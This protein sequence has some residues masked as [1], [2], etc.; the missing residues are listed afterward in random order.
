MAHTTLITDFDNTLYDWFHFWYHS[1]NAMLSV[2][3]RISGIGEETLIPQIRA[4]HQK[5]HTSEYAFL[6]Q[7][8]PCLQ[9]KFPNEDL[10]TVFDEA[11]HVYRKE[12]KDTLVLYEGVS[13][14]LTTLKK[15]GI[16][17]IIY[18]ESLAFYTHE[19]MKR[20]YLDEL[21]DFI[22]SPADH[23]L[24]E[25][26]THYLERKDAV[27]THA[28]HLHIPAGVVKPNPTVLRDIMQAIGRSAAECIYLGDS[29]MKDVAMAQDA[30]ITDVYAKYGGVQH[31]QEYELLRKVSHWTDADVQREMATSTRHVKPSHVI[32]KFAEI[33]RFFGE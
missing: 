26:V 25:G 32:S 8:L 30:G 18:T 1:F 3:C 12:R 6:I 17:I 31:R 21:V 15:K 24:P 20:F 22:Y 19:R 5:H 28:K 29:L 11:I 23:D 33:Q 16:Q 13:E 9:A 10:I 7:E 2:I 4:I 27:L 14:T